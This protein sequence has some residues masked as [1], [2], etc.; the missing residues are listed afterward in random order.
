M[1]L[2]SHCHSDSPMTSM[3][4]TAQFSDS[5]QILCEFVSY[6]WVII[7]QSAVRWASTSP[8]PNPTVLSVFFSSPILEVTLS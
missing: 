8:P 3:K 7:G 4:V 1:S 5:D 6:N 2:L